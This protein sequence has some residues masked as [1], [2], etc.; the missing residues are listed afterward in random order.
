MDYPLGA[1]PPQ[2]YQPHPCRPE[3]PGIVDPPGAYDHPSPQGLKFLICWTAKLKCSHRWW[4]GRHVQ[5][6]GDRGGL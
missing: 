2:L 6:F 4:K 3:L 1:P 5:G